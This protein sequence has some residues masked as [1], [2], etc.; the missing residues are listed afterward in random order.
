MIENGRVAEYCR[1]VLCR[2]EMSDMRCQDILLE[3]KAKNITTKVCSSKTDV[4]SRGFRFTWQC[5]CTNS[6]QSDK[7]EVRQLHEWAQCPFQTGWRYAALHHGLEVTAERMQN[8]Q[9]MS[10]EMI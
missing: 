1:K 6:E 4:S 9:P 8:S 10:I 7:F 5:V 3:F 2:V